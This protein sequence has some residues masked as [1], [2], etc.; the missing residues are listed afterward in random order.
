[1]ENSPYLVYDFSELANN[2]DLTKISL[3]QY[4][5]AF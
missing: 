2:K 3:G 4:K 1:M 5:A